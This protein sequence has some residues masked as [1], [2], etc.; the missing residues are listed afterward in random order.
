[1]AANQKEISS[2]FDLQPLTG[3]LGA[4]ILGV[5]LSRLDDDSFA[6]IHQAFLDY[7]VLVFR[8]QELSEE[9]FAEFGRRFGKL[10]DEPFLP[11]RSDTPGVFYL[12]GAGGKK[13]STQNLGWHVDHSYQTNPSL[14]AILYAVDVPAAGG[15]TLFSSNHLAYETLSPAMQEFLADKKAVH[16]VLHYGVSSGHMTMDTEKGLNTLA[17]MRKTRP[18]VE[19]P[20]VCTHPETGQKMLYCNQAWT[21]RISG[22]NPVESR[23]IISMLNEHALQPRFQCRVRWYNRSVLIWDNRAVQHSPIADYSEPRLMMRVALHSDWEPS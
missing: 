4:E 21:T 18:P 14:G 20:L 19:H 17:T 6:V 10:E 16:D 9:Q 11:H 22:L 13:L 23:A 7:S 2:S 5:D 8:D 15:D 12:K 3:A 1:M